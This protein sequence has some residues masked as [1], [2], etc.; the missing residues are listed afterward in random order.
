MQSSPSEE[1]V[2]KAKDLLAAKL[3]VS[4]DDIKVVSVL[5]GNWNDSSLGISEPG[6]M[7]MF[8]LV[9]G[10]IVRLEAQGKQ[11]QYNADQNGNLKFSEKISEKGFQQDATA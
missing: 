5:T 7:Y 11:Y 9:P 10:F 1:V 4:K 6:Q 8:M 2:A 3:N